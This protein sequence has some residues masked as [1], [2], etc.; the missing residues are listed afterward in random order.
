MVALAIPNKI[1]AHAV[2]SE[3]PPATGLLQP[4]HNLWMRLHAVGFLKSSR[5][6]ADSIAHHCNAGFTQSPCAAGQAE[7]GFQFSHRVLPPLPGFAQKSRNQPPAMILRA[8]RPMGQME[9]PAQFRVVS[10]FEGYGL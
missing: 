10:Q 3:E 6:G 5:T 9:H 2:P 7:S 1:D 4:F 8:A